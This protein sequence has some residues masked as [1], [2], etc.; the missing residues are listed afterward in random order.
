MSP[1]TEGTDVLYIKV[2]YN[3]RNENPVADDDAV[4][5]RCNVTLLAG[6]AGREVLR[7]HPLAG[8]GWLYALDAA[9]SQVMC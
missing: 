2:Y 9:A 4:G 7:E 6:A 8:E 5:S 3:S 1:V